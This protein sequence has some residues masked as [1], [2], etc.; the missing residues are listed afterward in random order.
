MGYEPNKLAQALIS[1]QSP[2]IGILRHSLTNPFH[3]EIYSELTTEL[4][5]VGLTPLT[6]Q[7]D[8]T[9]DIE[10]AL[11]MFQQYSVNRVVLIFFAMTEQ[12]LEACLASGLGV[13]LSN[14]VDAK[15]RTSAVCAD[16]AQGGFLAAD[17]VVRQQRRQIGIVEGLGG[18]WTA[19]M[20]TR[21]Y[22]RGLEAQGP[23][24]AWRYR[25][26]R[27]YRS[28]CE[29]ARA[30][31]AQPMDLDAVLCANDLMAFGVI[32]TLRTAGV[33]IPDDIAV[34]GFDDVPMASWGAYEL[35]TVRLAFPQMVQRL[36]PLLAPSM[37]S[38]GAKNQPAPEA[39]FAPCWLVEWKTAGEART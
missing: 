36:V 13:F 21:G 14:R 6:A 38:N 12:V 28:G 15:G 10:R 29:A 37:K 32:D 8:G 39:V 2:I 25:G 16:P 34:V 22:E 1:R 17:H 30:L 11:A 33:S 27:T 24:A 4:L 3:V 35:T 7:L 5:H 31:L 26:D 23:A 20:R 9:D 18:S 19:V